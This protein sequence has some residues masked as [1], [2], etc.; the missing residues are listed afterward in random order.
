MIFGGNSE[1]I[2][3]R[4]RERLCDSF[5]FFLFIYDSVRRF[6]EVRFLRDVQLVVELGVILLFLSFEV[7]FLSF[8][9]CWVFHVVEDN[10]ISIEVLHL[11]LTGVAAPA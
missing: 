1:R 3:E 2:G 9:C 11:D 8:D 10:V 6:V 4:M 7:F 5:F